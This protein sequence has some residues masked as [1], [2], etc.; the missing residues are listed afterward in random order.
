MCL[1]GQ[2]DGPLV[3][4]FVAVVK[5]AVGDTIEDGLSGYGDKAVYLMDVD[6]L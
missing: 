5:E 6:R 1:T 2:E 4:C 3:D